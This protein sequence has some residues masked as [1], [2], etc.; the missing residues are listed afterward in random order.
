MTDD[1]KQRIAYA[2]MRTWQAIGADCLV[3]EDGQPDESITLPRD[4]VIELVV[5]ADRL[6]EYGQDK[7]AATAYYDLPQDERDEIDR[8]AF[9]FE[10]Y[11]W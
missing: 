2:L 4:H 9:P 5:D 8:L 3:N 1:M 7:E 6:H 11:G 10:T